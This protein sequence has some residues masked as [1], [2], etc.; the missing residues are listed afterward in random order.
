MIPRMAGGVVVEAE[1]EAGVAAIPEG[2]EVRV[3][4]MEGRV[5]RSGLL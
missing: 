4:V 5:L 3:V 1:E 2:E